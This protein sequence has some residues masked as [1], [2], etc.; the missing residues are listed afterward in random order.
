MNPKEG[1]NDCPNAQSTSSRRNSR[2]VQFVEHKQF[3]NPQS[4]HILHSD[5]GSF[6]NGN[7]VMESVWSESAIPFV[8]SDPEDTV[9]L[10]PA[11]EIDDDGNTIFLPDTEQVE[12]K[13]HDKMRGEYGNIDFKLSVDF[14]PSVTI[15]NSENEDDDSLEDHEQNEEGNQNQGDP[16]QENPENEHHRDLTE[17]NKIDDGHTLDIIA[18]VSPNGYSPLFSEPDTD[19]KWQ[20]LPNV[21]AVTPI[22]DTVPNVDCNAANT[23]HK[24]IVVSAANDTFLCNIAKEIELLDEE[25]SSMGLLTEEHSRVVTADHST[26]ITK[27]NS[28]KGDDGNVTDSDEG[29]AGMLETDGIKS[30]EQI[31][32]ESGTL[33]AVHNEDGERI[34][35]IQQKENVDEPA[36]CKTDEPTKV[37]EVVDQIMNLEDDSE[38]EENIEIIK[39]KLSLLRKSLVFKRK[40]VPVEPKQNQDRNTNPTTNSPSIPQ[41]IGLKLEDHLSTVSN[42]GSTAAS[43]QKDNENVELNEVSKEFSTK[44][45]CQSTSQS[46]AKSPSKSFRS[47]DRVKQSMDISEI[48]SIYTDNFG[49]F[50]TEKHKHSFFDPFASPLPITKSPSVE[51]PNDKENE[52]EIDMNVDVENDLNLFQFD[53]PLHHENATKIQNQW[54]KYQFNAIL[55]TTFNRH[56]KQSKQNALPVTI[57]DL[58]TS[59]THEVVDH[60]EKLFNAVHQRKDNENQ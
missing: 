2:E 28:I 41:R 52:M 36:E 53:Q 38:D 1:L 35:I 8:H 50:I 11:D 9:N 47:P 32:D 21:I 3:S 30:I 27:A 51:P 55:I 34:Q 31:D 60:A 39:D 45:K 19:Q 56:L 48:M 22:E 17:H 49:E 24:N 16:N 29:L 37:D 14:L 54:K 59:T 40:T 43:K 25:L 46:A 26:V 13:K 15:E 18:A 33:V 6:L 10:L 23:V 57:T 7:S 12:P 5:G 4:P 20:E 44:S 42:V 58:I